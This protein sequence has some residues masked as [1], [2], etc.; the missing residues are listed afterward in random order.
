MSKKEQQN[1]KTKGVSFNL[2]D[3]LQKQLYDHAMKHTNFSSY[4]KALIQ[5]D[6]ERGVPVSQPEQ[7]PEP[8]KDH[9]I[10]DDIVKGFI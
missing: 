6:M 7:P 4:V 10:N 8:T 3:P 5:R 2:D 1:I 9:L